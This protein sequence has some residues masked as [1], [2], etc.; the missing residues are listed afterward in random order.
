MALNGW[1]GRRGWLGLWIAAAL[2]G[3][4]GPYRV[5]PPPGFVVVESGWEQTRMKAGDDVGLSVR[6]FPN[7]EGGTLAFWSE[8]LVAKLAHRG[9]VLGDTTMVTSK[10][11]VPGTRFQFDYTIPGTDAAKFLAVALFVTDDYR[12]VLQIAG[13]RARRDAHAG[14]LTSALATLHL[15]GCRARSRI[16][17]AASGG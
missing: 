2:T 7:H 16:C 6:H 1:I 9:Y 8:D 17:R 14:T 5:E 13:D 4:A 11:G 15:R 12:H 3:C 10:N